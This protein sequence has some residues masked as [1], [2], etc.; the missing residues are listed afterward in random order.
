MSHNKDDKKLVIYWNKKTILNWILL[1]ILT[2]I[3][4]TF[5]ITAT[6]EN[7]IAKADFYKQNLNE[8]DAYN[9]L[10][11]DGIP[12]LI[13]DATITDNEATNFLAKQ[14]II[15]VIQ[16]TVSPN[17]V[18]SEVNNILDKTAQ[19][20]SE[21]VKDEPN[22]SVKLENFDANITSISDGL[23]VLNQFIPSCEDAKNMQESDTANILNL[24]LNCESMNTNL[25]DIKAEITTAQA[26]I[27]TLSLKDIELTTSI[28]KVFDK[29]NL[30]KNYIVALSAAMWISL[31]LSILIVIILL[32]IN[33]K[34]IPSI[35]RSTSLSLAI[36]SFLVLVYATI[37][38]S[39]INPQIAN[40]IDLKISYTFKLLITDIAKV[41]IDN[42]FN[43]LITLSLIVFIIM[44]II[45]LVTYI[46]KKYKIHR[47]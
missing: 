43:Y 37:E 47:D 22:I 10:I 23:A 13:T 5:L 8:I 15:F 4:A 31:A 38:K 18:Q 36:S 24:P 9:R 28:Q 42:F 34:T 19:F 40:S 26:K 7:T 14:A 11:N 46:L 33:R 16:K 6:M 39:L 12:S 44:I 35:I 29:I 45:N 20:F 32:L 41:N 30:I 25:D 21:P 1:I 17:W 3:F 27:N 2:P